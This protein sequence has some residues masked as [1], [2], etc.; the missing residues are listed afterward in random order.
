MCLSM[1]GFAVNTQAFHQTQADQNA[2][3]AFS[4]APFYNKLPSKGGTFKLIFDFWIFDRIFMFSSIFNSDIT[5]LGEEGQ[6]YYVDYNG[7][8]GYIFKLF[9]TGK[10]DGRTLIINTNNLSIYCGESKNLTISQTNLSDTNSI[11]WT[12]SNT[13]V[14]VCSGNGKSCTV[15]SKSVGYAT[16]TAE[17]DGK[18]SVCYIYVLDKWKYGWQT[19]AKEQITLRAAPKFAAPAIVNIPQGSTV[20]ALGDMLSNNK[21]CYIKYK[22]GST[23]K[24]GYVPFTALSSQGEYLYEYG[25]FEWEYPLSSDYINISSYYGQRDYPT[26]PDHKGVDI[27]GG[28]KTTYTDSNGNKVSCDIIK[29]AEVVAVAN[30]TILRA[31]SDNSSGA[32]N[33]VSI[34]TDNIDP[35][36]G[37]NIIV[38]YMHLG[39]IYRGNDGEPSNIK[40]ETRIQ[41]GDP[42]G[43]V[44]NTNGTSNSSMGHHLH[45]EVTRHG[46]TWGP[47]SFANS[48][49]PL[50]FYPGIRFK[51]DQLSSWYGMYWSNDVTETKITF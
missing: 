18:K 28:K 44:S 7:E 15:K 46:E 43:T 6:Y 17:L 34:K 23:Y 12:S 29:D 26:V 45:F 2:R 16:V 51:T 5:I 48:V 14:A 3:L 31:R 37:N 33:Y 11:K 40:E 36:T 10:F 38:I 8:R 47:R 22:S 41:K 24:W 32:G 27:T 13:N 35:E 20:L 4:F 30:G 9:I 25:N 50:W 1:L 42:I 49:N 21:Y 19:T 39:K